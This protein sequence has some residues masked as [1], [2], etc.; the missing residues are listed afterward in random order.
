M[1]NSSRDIQYI[2][3]SQARRFTEGEIILSESDLER[4]IS[5]IQNYGFQ[6]ALPVRVSAEPHPKPPENKPPE[7]GRFI[8]GQG[9]VAALAEL[10]RRHRENP[11]EVEIPTGIATDESGWLMPIEIRAAEIEVAGEGSC[12][13]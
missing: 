11:G 1:T 7:N 6:D 8:Y 2:P 10:E 9:R 13:D 4:V 5:A 12:R 3:L